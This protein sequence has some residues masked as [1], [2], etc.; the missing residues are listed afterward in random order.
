MTNLWLKYVRYI[1]DFSVI[2]KDLT[3]FDSTGF[4]RLCAMDTD[5][6]NFLAYNKFAM[7]K[8]QWA[9][10]RLVNL[11]C[12]WKVVGLNLTQCQME[13]VSKPC[14]DRFLHPILVH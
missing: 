12:D 4:P 5:P 8:D 7:K 11:T 3:E 2:V 14:Q 13:M 9:K 1:C 10:V 6:E